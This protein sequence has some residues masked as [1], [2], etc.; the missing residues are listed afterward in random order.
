M[1]CI[2]IK[3]YLHN[4]AANSIWSAG[5]IFQPLIYLFSLWLSPSPTFLLDLVEK[6]FWFFWSQL[7]ILIHLEWAVGQLGKFWTLLLWWAWLAIAWGN[8][9]LFYRLSH[10]PT[11]CPALFPSREESNTE[12]RNARGLFNP[13]IIM[14]HHLFLHSTFAKESHKASLNSKE[15]KISPFSYWEA[16]LKKKMCGYRERWCF[17]VILKINDHISY[18]SHH[19]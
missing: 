6:F 9:I 3:L 19:H 12:S 11:G 2:S 18:S 14:A 15:D 17:L 5:I 10:H 13:R 16:T 4:Q 1:Y 7:I 8:S